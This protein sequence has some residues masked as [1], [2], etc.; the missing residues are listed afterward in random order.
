M[1]REEICDQRDV[2]YQVGFSDAKY[3]KKIFHEVTGMSLSQYLEEIT[4]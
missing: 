3:F 2:P 4:E 1:L